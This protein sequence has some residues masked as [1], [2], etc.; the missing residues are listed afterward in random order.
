MN[1]AET[2]HLVRNEGLHKIGITADFD[3]RV[4]ELASDHVQ[5]R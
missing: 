5:A 2:V 4:K 3:R 1:Y